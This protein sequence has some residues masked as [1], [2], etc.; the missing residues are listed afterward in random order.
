VRATEAS[1][2]SISSGFTAQID[3]LDFPA[4]LL[5]ALGGAHRFVDH[6]AVGDHRG[7]FAGADDARLADRQVVAVDRFGLEPAVEELVLAENDR[8]IERDASI[9][10][11]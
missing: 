8:V 1:T 7:V 6:R 4:V 10:M 3:D 2:V 5:Q 9:S 11:W